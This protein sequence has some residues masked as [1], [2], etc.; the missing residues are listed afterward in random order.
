MSKTV[1]IP[2]KSLEGQ[3]ATAFLVAGVLFPVGLVL[4]VQDASSI[5]DTVSPFLA[6]GA[7]VATFVGLFGM[8]PRLAEPAPK[9]ALA[10][11]LS[12]TVALLAIV[13]LLVSVVGSALLFGTSLQGEVGIAPVMFLLTLVT[14]GLSFLLFGVAG[15][16]TGVP[17]RVVGA[18]ML[19]PAVAWPGYM[20]VDRLLP[21]DIRFLPIAVFAVVALALLGVGY[22]LWTEPAPVD[23][24]ERDSEPAT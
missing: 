3:A 14:A 2:W 6:V 5:L 12:A 19:V 18:L 22:R 13:T 7:L 11:V 17:S 10:G 15:L 21:G 9:T 24:R 8:Y 16:R 4:T 1:N 23:R 20:A